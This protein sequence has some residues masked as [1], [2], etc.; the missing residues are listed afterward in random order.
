MSAF[1]RIANFTH[2]HDRF[3]ALQVVFDGGLLKTVANAENYVNMRKLS[4]DCRLSISDAVLFYTT[5]IWVQVVGNTSAIGFAFSHR[6]VCIERE[7]D[8]DI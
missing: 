1:G 2:N 5:D 6:P 7:A 3:C 8:H 4:G